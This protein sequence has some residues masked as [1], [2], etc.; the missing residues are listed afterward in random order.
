M[1]NKQSPIYLTGLAIIFT[2]TLVFLTLEA[3]IYLNRLLIDY[4]DIPDYNPA[5]NPDLIEEFIV[6]NNLRPIGYSCLILTILLVIIGFA[7]S[8]SKISAMGSAILFLPTFGHFVS[9]M[10][11]LSGLGVLRLIWIPLWGISFDLMRLG[12]IVYLPYMIITFT[13]SLL[14]SLYT[15]DNNFPFFRFLI[16][17]GMIHHYMGGLHLDPRAPL[18]IL[19][20]VLGILIFIVSTVAWFYTYQSENG[21]ADF[22]L[23]KYS[24]HPQYTGWIMWSYGVMLY[25]S[26]TPVVRGGINPGASLPWMLSSVIVICIALNEEIQMTR[27]IG[28]EYIHYRNRTPFLLPLPKIVVKIIQFPFKLIMKKN[29]PETTGEV[30]GTLLLYSMILITLSLPFVLLKWPSSMG[31]SE[32][33]YMLFPSTNLINLVRCFFF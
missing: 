15:L 19:L 20:V 14:F 5:I 31:W 27:R 7:T 4:L 1:K 18:A 30:I 28:E 11:F 29:S 13:L 12:D 33:P 3:P 24:R 32:W 2:V 16:E 8:K 22:W 26:L 9:Y 17:N 6:K 21:I 23:Y 10:F 25:A